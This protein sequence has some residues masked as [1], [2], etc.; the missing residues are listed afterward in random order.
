MI[1]DWSGFT[2]WL[3]DITTNPVFISLTSIFTTL[4]AV[5]IVISKTSIGTKALNKMNE[6]SRAASKQIEDMHAKAVETKEVVNSFKKEILE[7]EEA[8]K[9]ELLQK[10]NIVYNQLDMFEKHMIEIISEFPNI[11]IQN[12]L[13]EFKKEWEKEKNKIT[14]VMGESYSEVNKKYKELQEQIDALKEGISDGK[15]DSRTEEETL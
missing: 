3:T 7:K 1:L 5:L 2:Q 9:K 12:R 6:L 15:H 8:F 4:G 13:D 10:T 11:K 14:T